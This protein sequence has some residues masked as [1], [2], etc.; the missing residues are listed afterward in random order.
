M[1]DERGERLLVSDTVDVSQYVTTQKE[2][3]RDVDVFDI[4]AK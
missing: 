2:V 1:S 4:G 3:A